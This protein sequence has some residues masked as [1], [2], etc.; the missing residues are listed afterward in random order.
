[1]AAH[2]V[3]RL[4]RVLLVVCALA[5]A[6]A[7]TV[8]LTGGFAF[9]LDWLRVSSRRPQTALAVALL[10][11]VAAWVLSQPGSARTLGED[12]RWL[13]AIARER[14]RRLQPA[15]LLGTVAAVPLVYVW[16]GAR[17][18]WLDEEMIAIN[19]RDRPLASLAGPL[20]LGQS[21]PFGWLALQRAIV[22]TLGSDERALRLLPLLFGLATIGIALWVGARW[23][24]R[25]AATLFVV[26][27]G[28]GQWLFYHTLELKPYSADAFWGLLLPALAAW[29]VEAGPDRARHVARST[30]WWAVAAI[31]QW[32]ANGALFAAPGCALFLL[33][34]SWRRYGR[35]AALTF[36]LLG[37]VWLASFAVHYWAALRHTIGSGYL[38]AYWAFALPPPEAGWQETI[39]W[40]ARQLEPVALKPGGT[41]LWM[42]F[43]LLA[44]IGFLFGRSRPLAG[45]LATVPLSAFLLAAFGLVPLYERLTLWAVPNL[46][47]GIALAVDPVVRIGRNM[48]EHLRPVGL[49]TKGA[50]VLLASL[51]CYD[52]VK[53][54]TLDLRN[55]I[56]FDSHHQ[57]D[58]RRGVRWLMTER[59]EGDVLMATRLG[60]PAVW[61]YGEIPMTEE[62]FAGDRQSD[63]SRILE[64]GYVRQ[65]PR[66]EHDQLREALVNESRVLVYFG[67]RF[68]DVPGGFDGL[69]L[70]DLLEIGALV[71][72]RDFA[73][74]G[75]AAV[76]DL[77]RPPSGIEV[78]AHLAAGRPGASPSLPDG[79]VSVGPARR[80]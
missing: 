71:A 68:D 64:V 7:A 6:W 2:N 18:L 65:G 67:F 37:L 80:W 28:F 58:D 76:I 70:A 34:A 61:W 26:L 4:R 78:A 46:Y 53:L 42:I 66:C 9:R 40:L 35:R 38:R 23:M 41:G 49:V 32:I 16:A 45:V 22:L 51:L 27:C 69:L 30:A 1:M 79:C 11:G 47:A 24:N 55:G 62:K 39:G 75:R 59:Q 74:V 29:V 72:Y 21:A 15:A 13:G 8:A 36:S 17:P 44:T 50:I 43:W 33:V 77:R 25:V 60:L 48:Y 31:G 57:L 5:G 20:W 54:G 12:F 3:T 73:E 56:P 19:I 14:I 10:C 63:G 52:V